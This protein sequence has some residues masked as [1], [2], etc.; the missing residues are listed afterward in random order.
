MNGHLSHWGL[1]AALIIT[2]GISVLVGV[3]LL[4]VR[5][6]STPT[7]PASVHRN[8]PA[9]ESQPAPSQSPSL[10]LLSSH[11]H[12]NAAGD[13]WYIDGEIRNLTAQSLSNLQVVSVW[14]DQQ[15]AA[16]AQSTDLVDLKKVMPGEISPFSSATRA[17]PEMSTFR[18]QFKSEIGVPLLARD[19]SPAP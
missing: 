11:A 5:S 13:F 6:R 8:L 15:G 2:V 17:R 9:A 7:P 1:T 3:P 4:V 16:V 12:L 19:G 10:A 14:Y 18:L